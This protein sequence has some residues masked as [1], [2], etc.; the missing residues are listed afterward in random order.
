MLTLASTSLPLVEL[1]KTLLTPLIFHSYMLGIVTGKITTGRTSAGFK[2]AV[3][4]VLVSM[5]GIWMAF[6]FKFF[7][8]G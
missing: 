2:H 4:L 1:G 7:S 3:I 6:H 5:L 8:F